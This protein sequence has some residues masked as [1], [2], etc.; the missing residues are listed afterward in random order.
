MCLQSWLAHTLTI[1]TGLGCTHSVID[2]DKVLHRLHSRLYSLYATQNREPLS[3]I[4]KRK[5]V[6]HSYMEKQGRFP[7]STDSLPGPGG[8]TDWPPGI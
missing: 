8:T 2:L 5:F 6:T 1:A 3:G 4:R 7:L